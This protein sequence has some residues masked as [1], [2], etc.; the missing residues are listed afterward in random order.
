MVW[1][2]SKG[3]HTFTQILKEGMMSHIIDFQQAGEQTK[4]VHAGEY[5]DPATNASAPNIV[6][7][8]TYVTGA[9]TT[10]SV[11]GLDENDPWIYT[12]WGNPTIHQ[13][14]EKLAAL[15]E[16]ET[17]VAF[18]SG[19][20]A[21]TALL[22]HLLKAGDHAIVSDVAYA[23]LSEITNE[24]IPALNIEITKVDTSDLEA[25]RKALKTNT[26]L[27]YIETPCNPLLRLTDIEAAAGIAH[28]AGARLAVDSTFATPL[29]TKPLLLGA[30]FVVHSLTKYLGGHGDALGGVILG[31][32]A[33]LTPL[34]KKTAIRLGGTL[35]P[36]N[37]WLIMRGIATFPLRMRVH[38]ENALEVAA[39]LERHPKV[40]RVIYPGLPSHPQYELARRQMRNFSGILT[41]QVEDGP[42]VAR[43]VA[44]KL[45]IIH[46]AVS[47]G[48]HRSLIFHLNSKDLLQTSFRFS[49][50]EQ[51]AS[52]NTFA[53][54][55]IFRLS[56]G[57]EDASD[58]IADLEQALG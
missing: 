35:S 11:E 50:E 39:Y 52:W 9:D 32:K 1:G 44:E 4:A 2:D 22:L 42:A 12:R 25:V 58:L 10:F 30:D 36:F 29:A 13:L 41:F 28:R 53:G 18:A 20:S 8:T 19:M 54:D 17:A 37:A 45:R 21:I 34:R 55:G 3:K 6:M 27:V 51:L 46:Y 57:L 40:K 48:H 43:R 47:L 7:S 16:A 5:P 24:M 31:S 56:I 38:Q 14:E 26:K 23:A 15:E 49:T 33:A